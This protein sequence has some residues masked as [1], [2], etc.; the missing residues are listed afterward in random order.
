M[1]SSDTA[2]S[3][4]P[5]S[6]HTIEWKHESQSHSHGYVV[7]FGQVKPGS[8]QWEESTSRALRRS[9]AASGACVLPMAG[10]LT[11]MPSMSQRVAF[12]SF[13]FGA[14]D[15]VSVV[16][17]TWM[18]ALAAMGADVV[19][20]TGGPTDATRTRTGSS[21]G[22]VPTTTSLPNRSNRPCG[23]RWTT[24]TWPWSRTC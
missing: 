23:Q 9:S 1:A 17:R 10:T 24:S 5:S 20:V 4:S 16:A 19:T 6:A 22:S 13:R 2:R 7:L 3:G 12:V 14:T 21:T 8:R 15:G 11:C 18:D